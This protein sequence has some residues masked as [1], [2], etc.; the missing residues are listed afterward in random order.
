MLQRT[1]G[2]DPPIIRDAEQSYI[3]AINDFANRNAVVAKLLET[4]KTP[5]NKPVKF[6]GSLIVARDN[7][8]NLARLKKDNPAVMTTQEAIDRLV[9]FRHYDGTLIFIL[10]GVV[11][12]EPG[13]IA[14]VLAHVPMIGAKPEAYGVS[15]HVSFIWTPKEKIVGFNPGT[16][17]WGTA[18]PDIISETVTKSTDL[19]IEWDQIP[20]IRSIILRA[21]SA[22][23]LVGADPAGPQDILNVQA[24]RGDAFCQTWSVLWILNY[25][26]G[27]PARHWPQAYSPLYS[28]IRRF[29]LWIMVHFPEIRRDANQ[30][31]QV[32]HPGVDVYNLLGTS[33][34]AIDPA[35]TPPGP[36]LDMADY[37]FCRRR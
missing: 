27:C 22:T 20:D 12:R 5:K 32:A 13:A 37:I 18:L 29:I 6:L 8:T 25:L 36:G 2:L 26:H 17:C 3:S 4:Y 21:A 15:H 1:I 11:W 14:R 24:V 35:V 30:E 10:A 7:D 34:N 16:S 23:R 28:T 19:T 33:W 31:F 9:Q